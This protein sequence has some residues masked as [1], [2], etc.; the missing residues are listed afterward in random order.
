MN[1]KSFCKKFY[2][3]EE[4][5][6]PSIIKFLF[7]VFAIISV[8]Y[9]IINI[10]HS[11]GGSYQTGFG[12]THSNGSFSLFIFGVL[13]II[14]GVIFSKIFCEILVIS[15]KIND[16]LVSIKKSLADKKSD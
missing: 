1:I 8:I 9:G 15:F 16:N 10:V 14:L 3:F 2:S 6:T 7:W 12:V 5:I 11:F 4:M 13:Q